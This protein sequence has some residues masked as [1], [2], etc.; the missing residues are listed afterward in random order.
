MTDH[1]RNEWIADA[2][3]ATD[4]EA[5]WRAGYEAQRDVDLGLDCGWVSDAEQQARWAADRRAVE[6]Q[7]AI[8]ADAELAR[9]HRWWLDLYGGDAA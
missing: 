4:D 3:T 1:A 5:D 9:M 6:E 7:S 8:E 2:L